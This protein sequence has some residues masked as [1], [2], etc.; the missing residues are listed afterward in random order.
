MKHGRPSFTMVELIVIV[1]ITSILMGIAGLQYF[2]ITNRAKAIPK[3]EALLKAIKT[4]RATTGRWPNGD[5]ND[6]I[7]TVAEWI[8][9]AAG[10]LVDA[11][12]GSSYPGWCG[13]YIEGDDDIFRDPWGNPIMY[14]GNPDSEACAGCASIYSRGPDGIASSLDRAD[15]TAQGDDIV[16]YLN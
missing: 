10:L 6:D 8:S 4:L 11:G 13:P 3:L 2:K 12:A 15:R 7:S 14:D 5:A 16:I 1:V 9:G